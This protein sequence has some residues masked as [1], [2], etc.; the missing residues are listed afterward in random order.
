MNWRAGLA[1]GMVIRAL[2]DPALWARIV[3]EHNKRCGG[4]EPT[5]GSPTE[6]LEFAERAGY[7]TRLA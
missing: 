6:F 4:S 7:V 5:P 2:P 1:R 3:D